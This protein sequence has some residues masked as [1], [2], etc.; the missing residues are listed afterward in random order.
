MSDL[1]RKIIGRIKPDWH[2]LIL[3]VSS[4]FSTEKAMNWMGDSKKAVLLEKKKSQ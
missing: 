2:T 3:V 4:D 1:G